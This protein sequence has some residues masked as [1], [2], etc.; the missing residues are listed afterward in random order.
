MFTARKKI[1][2]EG[3]ALPTE[4]EDEVAKAIFDLEMN[5][6]D[7][8]AEL[9]DL[10]FLSA[11]EVDVTAGKKAIVVV[12]PFRQLQAYHKIQRSLVRE[13]EKKFSGKHVIV[14][15]QRYNH[16]YVNFF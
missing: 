9:K 7:L 13:L 14:I 2:K 15:A 11:K 10:T 16:C 12:V 4:L 8:K 1:T 6:S 5:S 3:G